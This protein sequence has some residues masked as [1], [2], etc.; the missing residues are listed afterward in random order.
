VPAR[1]GANVEVKWSQTLAYVSGGVP[2]IAHTA[3]VV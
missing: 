3:S 1:S 2:V